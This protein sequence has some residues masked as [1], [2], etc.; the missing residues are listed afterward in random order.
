MKL[1]NHVVSALFLTAVDEKIL[2]QKNLNYE[3]S[4]CYEEA[5]GEVSA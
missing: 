5:A 2:C 3:E 1:K 4:K